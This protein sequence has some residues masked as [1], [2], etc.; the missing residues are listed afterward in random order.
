MPQVLLPSHPHLPM[1]PGLRLAR[2]TV[3]REGAKLSSTV[4]TLGGA[5]LALVMIGDAANNLVRA[6]DDGDELTLVTAGLQTIMAESIRFAA[7][8]LASGDSRFREDWVQRYVGQ[9]LRRHSFM[10]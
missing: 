6:S 9:P 4:H 1:R 8:C 2:G 5:A 10:T 7:R 3:W